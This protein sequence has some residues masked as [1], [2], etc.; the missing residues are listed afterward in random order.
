MKKIALTLSSVFLLTGCASVFGG[1]AEADGL[2]CEQLVSLTS[3]ENLNLDLLDTANL[4][5]EIRT[6]ASAVAGAE[7]APRIDALATELEKDPV[8]VAA[9]A[10]IAGEVALRCAV[11][12]VNFDFTNLTNVLG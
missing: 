3:T 10:P 12:G 1:D 8:S 9:V 11:V 4:A 5:A 7:F 6:K 2:A